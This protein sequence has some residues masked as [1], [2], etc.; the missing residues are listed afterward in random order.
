MSE[1]AEAELQT[2]TGTSSE[3]CWGSLL[4]PGSRKVG[5]GVRSGPCR[6]RCLF[7]NR[8]D[9]SLPVCRKS[10]INIYTT[11]FIQLPLK[12][13]SGGKRCKSAESKV[14]LL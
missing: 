8:S 7:R 5:T 13:E 14:E 2:Q 4:R 9:R 6:G 11:H 12:E 10:V 1:G 3:T